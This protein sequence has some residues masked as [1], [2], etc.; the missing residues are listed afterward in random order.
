MSHNKLKAIRLEHLAEFYKGNPIVDG[1]HVVNAIHAENPNMIFPQIP[2]FVD[3]LPIYSPVTRGASRTSEFFGGERGLLSSSSYTQPDYCFKLNSLKVLQGLDEKANLSSAQQAATLHAINDIYGNSV[4]LGGRCQFEKGIIYEREPFSTPREYLLL[5]LAN[6]RPDE[7]YINKTHIKSSELD[8]FVINHE[9]AHKLYYEAGLRDE[10]PNAFGGYLEESVCDTYAALKHLQ[11]GYD[12]EL[13]QTFHD[14]R[15]SR[16]MNTS[17]AYKYA[18]HPSLKVIVENAGELQEDLQDMSQE[19]LFKT[20]LGIV[21]EHSY[22]REAYYAHAMVAQAKII[23]DNEEVPYFAVDWQAIEF[24]ADYSSHTVRQLWDEYKEGASPKTERAEKFGIF[25]R[26]S[27]MA[28]HTKP[29]NE[30]NLTDFIFEA[31]ENYSVNDYEDFFKA[32]EGLTRGE[33]ATQEDLKAEVLG[34]LKYVAEKHPEKTLNEL[35][36]AREVYLRAEANKYGRTIP[37]GILELNQEVRRHL[38]N[39]PVPEREFFQQPTLHDDR[40][41]PER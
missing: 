38:E 6:L 14:A 16:F 2:K 29:S 25:R 31:C 34:Q 39:P 5:G 11:N 32:R 15:I 23:Y 1:R 24:E 41:A 22:D 21:G 20:A 7:A 9:V 40:D 17:K 10:D 12:E 18:T 19:D 37:S 26:P 30:N 4:P 8:A 3:L 13:I 27:S 33:L 28:R 36:T 35:L